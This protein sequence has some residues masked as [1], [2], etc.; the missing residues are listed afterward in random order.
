MENSQAR[1]KFNKER[2]QS[3]EKMKNYSGAATY[4][5]KHFKTNQNLVPADLLLWGRDCYFAAAAIDSA[6]IALD[7]TK[8]DERLALYLKA[9]SILGTLPYVIPNI[10]WAISG[11]H[12]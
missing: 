8:A 7:S 2:I 11:G 5:E 10:I 9:D 3:F 12:V 4:L 6:A 1:L